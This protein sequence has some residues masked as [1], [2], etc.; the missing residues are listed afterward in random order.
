MNEKSNGHGEGIG[1]NL[2][3]FVDIV[4]RYST[5]RIAL[6]I[7]IISIFSRVT[8]NLVFFGRYGNHA[9][10]SLET[11]YYYGF[12]KGIFDG[13]MPLDPTAYILKF[14]GWIFPN[15]LLIYIIM[16][17]GIILTSFTAVLI[18]LL[19]KE[20][21]DKKTGFIAGVIYAFAVVPLILNT[22]SFTHDHVQMP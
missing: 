13:L 9:V 4:C 15:G 7:F 19:A 8:L 22:A 5:A 1:L 12:A 20:F 14:V 18:F 6:I 17:A 10:N 2:L 11:W 3:N 21:H 16:T